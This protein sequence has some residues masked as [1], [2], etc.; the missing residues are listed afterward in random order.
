MARVVGAGL[1]ANRKAT[2]K[3]TDRVFIPAVL[4]AFLLSGCMPKPQPLGPPV[5]Q[6]TDV[7]QKD[8][9]MYGQWVGTLDGNINAEIRAMVSGYLIRQAYEDGKFVKKGDLLFEIDPRPFQAALDQARAQLVKNE[10]DVA[11]LTPLAKQNAVSQQELDNA[12]QARAGAQAQVDA[13]EVN[14]GFTKITSPVD[15]IAAIAIPG[16][17]NLVSPNSGPLT[18]VSQLDPIKVNFIVGEQEYLR[19]VEQFLDGNKPLSGEV[20]HAELALILASG[21]VY[22]QKGKVVAVDRQLDPRT[23]SIRLTGAF[24]NPEYLL[25]PGQFARVRAK[26]GVRQGALLV[27]QRAVTELQGS[28]QV[29]VVGADNKV[30]IRNVEMGPREGSMWIVAKGLN[31]G[32]KV[33][34]E[35]VQKVKDGLLVTVQPFAPGAAAPAAEPTPKAE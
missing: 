8:V 26:I 32:E 17:G 30:T 33:V 19:Y 3:P 16:L 14:L 7:V 28:Y 9:P 13:A 2:M 29:A 23:G 12:I 11:R 27:P 1:S 24:P 34:A 4:F 20:F 10:Q 22:P 35:G 31:P 6:V 15:G 25:R 21:T 18:T 5:V